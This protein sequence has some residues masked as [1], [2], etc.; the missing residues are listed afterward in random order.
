MKRIDSVKIVRREDENPDLSYLESSDVDD[1]GHVVDSCRYSDD[2]VK[3]HGH[4]AVQGWIDQDR[5][6]LADYGRTWS[7]VGVRAE[8]Q[9]ATGGPK[10]W[11]VQ[12]VTS[13]GLWGIESDSDE[14]YF[15]EVG[16]EEL[17]AL[18]TILE[19]LGFASGQ[20]S[21]AFASVETVTP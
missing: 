17:A 18:R 19:D 11:T 12:T 10:Y 20:I 14:S 13:G 8:A 5:A 21:A 3:T 2:D 15:D 1:S 9:I 4:A 7:C 6:R 16:A